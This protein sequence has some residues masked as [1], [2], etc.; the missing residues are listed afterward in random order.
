MKIKQKRLAEL[1]IMLLCAAT[2]L[3]LYMPTTEATSQD[4]MVIPN[5][6]IRLRILAD[7]DLEKDQ[8]IKRKVRDAVNAEITS[9]VEN[10][11]SLEEARNVIKEG[12][13]ELQK[14]AEDVVAEHGSNQTVKT[15]F[16]K[17]KFPTKLYGQYLYPAGEYEAVLITLGEGTGSNWWC[18]LFPPLCFLDFSNGEATSPGFENGKAVE[19]SSTEKVESKEAGE[20]VEEV[21]ANEEIEAEEQVESKGTEEQVEEVEV[22]KQVAEVVVEE[23]L[24]ET[25]EEKQVEKGEIEEQVEEIVTEVQ[26]EEVEAAEKLV[27]EDVAP[28]ATAEEQE[29]NESKKE[30]KVQHEEKEADNLV[31]EESAPLYEDEEEEKVEVKFFVV[32]IWNKIFS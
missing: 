1:Y 20:Q 9:W 12:I 8:E 2:I 27:E 13:P 4:P 5:E 31:A 18:V 30:S 29:A 7:S 3:N 15:E 32:E 26:V 11:V 19:A 23:Q 21:E 14:I 22:V 17:V 24:E 10:L 16:N 25:V 6:A 28:T